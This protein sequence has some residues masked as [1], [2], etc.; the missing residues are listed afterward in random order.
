MGKGLKK[1]AK[2]PMKSPFS[3]SGIP[4]I[5]FPKVTPRPKLMIRLAKE[6]THPR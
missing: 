2:V 6:K 3:L 1:R 5:K 4:M